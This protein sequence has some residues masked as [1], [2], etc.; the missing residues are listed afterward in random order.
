[1]LFAYHYVKFGLAPVGAVATGPS[2]V[3]K[4]NVDKIVDVFNNNPNVIGSQ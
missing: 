3:D 1:M 4:K 2:I